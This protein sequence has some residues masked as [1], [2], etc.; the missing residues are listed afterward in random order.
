MPAFS[1]S[2]S[3]RV[4]SELRKIIQAIDQNSKR[5]VRRVGLTGPQLVILKAVAQHEEVSVGEIAR[6]VS[7][8]QGTVTGIVER[9]VVRDLILRWKSGQDRRRVMVKA[10]ETGHR[11]LAQAPPLMQ[12]AFMSRFNQ[13]PAWRQTM[14]LSSLQQLSTIMDTKLADPALLDPK[15]TSL[16]GDQL[17]K[18]TLPLFL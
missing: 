14:V 12:E 6:D 1:L 17:E 5:L 16:N 8:S 4:I 11:L 18:E 2:V 3:D 10:T 13:L 7:L 15:T 9:L